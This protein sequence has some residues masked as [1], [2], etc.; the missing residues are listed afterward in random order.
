MC[1]IFDAGCARV[2]RN[3][4]STF[5]P[6][7]R[8][9]QM[10]SGEREEP[11]KGVKNR[12]AGLVFLPGSKQ[13]RAISLSL[14][15]LFI[16]ANCCVGPKRAGGGGVLLVVR[17]KGLGGLIEC[18][19][20]SKCCEAMGLSNCRC[21]TSPPQTQKLWR[22]C[23]SNSAQSLCVGGGLWCVC[24]YANGGGGVAGLRWHQDLVPAAPKWFLPPGSGMVGVLLPSACRSFLQLGS[25]LP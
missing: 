7:T 15:K 1:V 20:T 18:I 21:T 25:S 2:S 13:S 24:V 5:F 11:R 3:S 14:Q 4:P 10:A 9:S 22:C 12:D 17:K 8:P 23:C 16:F 19:G 6:P